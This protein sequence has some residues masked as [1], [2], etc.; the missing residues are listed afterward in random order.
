M[1]EKFLLGQESHDFI[2]DWVPQGNAQEVVENG[3][4]I[5]MALPFN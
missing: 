2:A 1:E 5:F 4:A 3:E